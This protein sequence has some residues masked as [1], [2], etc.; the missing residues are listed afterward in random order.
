MDWRDSTVIENWIM[1]INAIIN[2]SVKKNQIKFK[3]NK[4][5]KLNKVCFVSTFGFSDVFRLESG[6]RLKEKLHFLGVKTG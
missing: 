3:W 1:R 5:M 2:Q 4:R 6:K